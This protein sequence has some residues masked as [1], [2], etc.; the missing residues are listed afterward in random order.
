[1]YPHGELNRLAARK[2]LLE[3]RIALRR[4]ECTLAATEAARPVAAFDRALQTWHRISPFVKIL[5]VPLGLI[6]TRIVARKREGKPTGKS[7]FAALMT[8]LPIIVRVVNML[9]DAHSTRVSRPPAAARP[10]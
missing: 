7:K 5:G 10:W 4:L 8:A 9:K 2:T 1:M 3:A 6:L